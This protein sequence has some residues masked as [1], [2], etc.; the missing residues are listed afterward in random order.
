MD[1]TVLTGRAFSF[2]QRVT[3]DGHG[4][5]SSSFSSWPPFIF[6]LIPQCP[7]PDKLTA[8]FASFLRSAWNPV[9]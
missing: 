6:S 2:G 7:V 4:G 3:F 9:K 1:L 8:C 5:V